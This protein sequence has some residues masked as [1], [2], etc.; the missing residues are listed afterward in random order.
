M[1]S[2]VMAFPVGGIDMKTVADTTLIAAASGKFFMPTAFHFTFT[3]LT[4]ATGNPT[5]KVVCGAAGAITL[6]DTWGIDRAVYVQGSIASTVITDGSNKWLCDLANP[7]L[8]KVTIG[9][10][11]TT[12]TGRASI[13]GEYY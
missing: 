12:V 1:A 6:V 11:G 4:G 9:A 13:H 5:V 10:T 2:L 7:V 8:F 3:N